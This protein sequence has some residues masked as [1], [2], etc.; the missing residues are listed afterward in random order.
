MKM[1]GLRRFSGRTLMAAFIGA[2]G[3]IAAPREK[4]LANEI[5]FS[6]T[7]RD[8]DFVTAGVGGLRNSSSGAI[9]LTGLSGTVNKAYLYWHGP[10]NV[11][12]P[13]ANANIRLNGRNITG[14]SLGLSDDNCWG[15]LNSAAY[16]A[17][18][19]SIV[20]TE[21]NG[22]YTLSNFLKQGT[23]INANGAS[24]M[25]FYNDT[26]PNNNRDI[27]LF[28]G[29]DSNAPNPYDDLGWNVGLRNISYFPTNVTNVYIQ[30]HISDGQSWD[31]DAVIVNNTIIQP[32]GPGFQ[33]STVPSNNNGPENNG[34]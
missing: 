17:D 10:M 12:D 34:S 22:T 6:E 11:N 4:V 19:T 9:N 25:V 8:T 15:F 18:V 29:N 23:N 14:T 24:L 30:L 32:V 1:T 28:E 26:N 33:G 5:A 21:R 2:L 20:R 13:L 16:R 3:V 27:V 7:V 31:D